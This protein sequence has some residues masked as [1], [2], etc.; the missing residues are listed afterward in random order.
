[1]NEFGS[2]DPRE[3]EIFT[4]NFTSKLATSEIII[5]SDVIVSVDFGADASCADLLIGDSFISGSKIGQL[6]T[7]GVLGTVY[8]LTCEITTSLSQT[9]I[10]SGTVE[11]IQSNG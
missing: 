6:I 3:T 8:L 7:G 10:L 1:M 5:T 2:K 9:L 11:I 4:F